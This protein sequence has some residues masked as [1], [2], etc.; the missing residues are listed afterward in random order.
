[1]NYEKTLLDVIL[2]NKIVILTMDSQIDK[3]RV[4]KLAGYF[5]NLKLFAN[6]QKENNE[7]GG[8][9]WSLIE[10]ARAKAYK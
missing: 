2:I 3:F 6:S 8:E 9:L 4:E 5:G 1:M 7:K 10:E